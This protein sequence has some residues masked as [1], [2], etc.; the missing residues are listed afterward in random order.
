MS[1]LIILFISSFL[2]VATYGERVTP[3][4]ITCKTN[5]VYLPQGKAPNCDTVCS[6]LG[7]ICNVKNVWAPF[8]CYCIKGYARNANNICIPIRKCPPKPIKSTTIKPTTTV[9][10]APASTNVCKINEKWMDKGKDC[11]TV[12]S[13]LG[14]PC[15]TNWFVQPSGCYCEDGY[16]RDGN[17]AC[18]LINQCPPKALN[19]NVTLK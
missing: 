4:P 9:K 12:C 8:G 19:N 6:T 5:E 16:A 3:A 11:D 17:N 15:Y 18:I 2:V 7:D 10:P 13:E 14:E 1:Q